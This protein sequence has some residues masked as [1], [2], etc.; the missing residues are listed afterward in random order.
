VILRVERLDLGEQLFRQFLTR[1]DGKARNVVDR[2]FR[3]ELGALTTRPVENVD[4]MGFEI[5]QA[6]LKDGKQ[7][8]RSGADDD[9][10]RLDWRAHSLFHNRLVYE[11]Q[12]WRSSYVKMGRPTTLSRRG[13][14][15]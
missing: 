14:A 5:E 1:D 9:D 3:I 11:V 12:N 13:G 15:M 8:D 2:L 7:P 10:I 6:Q 4:E